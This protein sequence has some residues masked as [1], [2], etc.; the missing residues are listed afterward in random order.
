MLLPWFALIL[1]VKK[2]W[3]AIC[4]NVLNIIPLN[5][6]GHEKAIKLAKKENDKDQRKQNV[7]KRLARNICYDLL[8][9][10]YTILYVFYFHPQAPKNMLPFSRSRLYQWHHICSMFH[11]QAPIKCCHFSEANYVSGLIYVAFFIRKNQ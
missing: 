3:L 7:N 8:L 6:Y 2:R 4:N 9:D 1:T 5:F 10:V 11:P